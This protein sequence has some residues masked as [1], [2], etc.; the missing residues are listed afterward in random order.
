MDDGERP[1]L[2]CHLIQTLTSINIRPPPTQIIEVEEE[3]AR[4]PDPRN[5]DELDKFRHHTSKQRK[6][7]VN[8]FIALW[9]R[10]IAEQV[11]AA[12]RDGFAVLTEH[13][14]KTNIK[15]IIGYDA[16][17]FGKLLYIYLSGGRDQVKI[18]L[19]EWYKFLAVFLEEGECKPQLRICFKLLDIDND[20]CLNVLN[21]LHLQK[22]ISNTSPLGLEVMHI[23]D[24]FM[25][26]NIYSKNIRERIP[27]TFDIFCNLLNQKCCLRDEIRQKFL[28]IG[29]NTEGHLV[30]RNPVPLD[31]TTWY[32]RDDPFIPKPNSTFKSVFKPLSEE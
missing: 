18:T 13:N 29:I 5:Y 19:A 25:K 26:T 22:N 1:E 8:T 32:M 31:Y 6:M 16:P 28:G 4:M 2:L 15:N 12:T 24:H 7:I 21:L 14:F 30:T 10:T 11:P 20:G 3:K 17:Y 23:V 27:I 9:G